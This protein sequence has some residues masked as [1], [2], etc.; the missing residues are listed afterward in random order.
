MNLNRGKEQQLAYKVHK[1]LGQSNI[2]T[3]VHYVSYG[4][5][6]NKN[7]FRAQTRNNSTKTDEMLNIISWDSRKLQLH[8]RICEKIFTFVEA[9]QQFS[10]CTKVLIPRTVTDVKAD[11]LVRGCNK[12]RKLHS[13]LMAVCQAV[14]CPEFRCMPFK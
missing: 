13:F 4:T 1:V 2:N 9:R 3:L 6:D 10:G 12:Y 11:F 8:K 14:S 7:P 5:L